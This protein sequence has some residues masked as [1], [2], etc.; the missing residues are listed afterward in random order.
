MNKSD[1]TNSNNATANNNNNKNYKISRNKHKLNKPHIV[2]TDDDVLIDRDNR[3]R[4]NTITPNKVNSNHDVSSISAAF[5]DAHVNEKT[6]N[7]LKEEHIDT[8][9]I[10]WEYLKAETGIYLSIYI[11]LSIYHMVYFLYVN[12]RVLLLPYKIKD[13]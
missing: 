13:I 11:F 2:F 10:G 8:I 1:N 12:R 4:N 9:P 7:I 5:D 6:D 3:S